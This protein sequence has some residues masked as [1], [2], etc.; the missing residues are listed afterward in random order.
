M[1]GD[2]IRHSSFVIRHSDFGFRISDF[3]LWLLEPARHRSGFPL[4]SPDPVW[5]EPS[6]GLDLSIRRR[7]SSSC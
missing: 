1:S 4:L 2:S 7:F 5:P 3:E 6:G